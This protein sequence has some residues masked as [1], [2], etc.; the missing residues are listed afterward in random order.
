MLTTVGNRRWISSD[1]LATRSAA[2]A[3]T[4]DAE[5]TKATANGMWRK[6]RRIERM[7]VM[8]AAPCTDH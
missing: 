1:R 2:C 4:A 3:E 5:S 8:V 6:A 7:S